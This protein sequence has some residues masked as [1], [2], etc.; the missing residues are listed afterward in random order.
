MD[1]IEKWKTLCEDAKY[2]SAFDLWFEEMKKGPDPQFKQQG[3]IAWNFMSEYRQ[4]L[5]DNKL[6]NLKLGTSPVPG[7]IAP[8]P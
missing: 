5:W 8:K 2:Q 6:M 4:W 7:Y 1:L 3:H